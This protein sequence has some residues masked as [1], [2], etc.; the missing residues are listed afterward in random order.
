MFTI[1][2]H[3]IIV[4][5]LCL[6]A[7]LEL[8]A[9]ENQPQ[10]DNYT[11]RFGFSVTGMNTNFQMKLADDFLKNDS[12]KTIKVIPFYGF[13]LGAI[14][15]LKL[16]KRWSLRTLP[17]INFAQRNIEYD[18]K[19]STQFKSVEV[20]SAYID[21]PLLFKYKSQRHKNW[22]VYVI[23]GIKF[24]YDLASNIDAPRS[25]NDPIVALQPFSYS[26]EF[27]VGMDLFFPLFKLSPEIKFGQSINN[28]LVPDDYVYTK[29]LGGLF[30]R[31]VTFSFHFE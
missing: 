23:G 9:Q 16:S 26:Y 21:L 8:H 25:L 18:F 20:E 2:R 30:S 5:L 28:V 22:R 13:G 12:I 17:S 24:T 31:V 7:G 19:D 3:K 6:V 15:D 11:I 14:A 10:Y 27:G 29:T 4:A 1:H